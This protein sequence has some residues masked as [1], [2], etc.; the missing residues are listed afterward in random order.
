MT[1]FALMLQVYDLI[2][3]SAAVGA[4]GLAQAVPLV[5][6]SAIPTFACYDAS[7]G[8]AASGTAKVDMQPVG[9]I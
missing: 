2:H 1:G 8:P 3:S 9:C 5:L 4:I 6:R 7:A